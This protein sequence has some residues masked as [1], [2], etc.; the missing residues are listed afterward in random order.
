MSFSWGKVAV[1]QICIVFKGKQ[2]IKGSFG[3]LVIYRSQGGRRKA[4]EYSIW[5]GGMGDFSAILGIVA[6]L[7]T[8][9]Y[10]IIF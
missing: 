7:Y 6:V 1:V 2:E 9:C 8:Q 5:G 10:M 4:E 3:R